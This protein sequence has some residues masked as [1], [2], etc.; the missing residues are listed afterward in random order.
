MSNLKVIALLKKRM[1][2]QKKPHLVTFERISVTK[3]VG[4]R[5]Y[6]LCIRFCA[7]NLV[8]SACRNNLEPQKPKKDMDVLYKKFTLLLSNTNH[9]MWIERLE[10]SYIPLRISSTVNTQLA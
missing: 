2:F 4:T 10:S 7:V 1:R 5:K 6:K 3:C 8:K 9:P